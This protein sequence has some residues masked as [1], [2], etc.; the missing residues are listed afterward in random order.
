[1]AETIAHPGLLLGM[2]RFYHSPRLSMRGVLD[3]APTESRLLVYMMFGLVIMLAGKLLQLAMEVP[4]GTERF[5]SRAVA[6]AGAWLFITPL[7]YYALAAIGTLISKLFRGHGGWQS[8]RAAF[9]WASLVSAPIMAL[10]YIV[11]PMIV[12]APAWVPA[13]VIQLGPV[14]FIWA[15]AQCFAE[16]FEFRQVWMVFATMSAPILA[17]FVV[18]RLAG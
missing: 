7:V 8:G 14:F 12:S 10:S 13:A 4:P 1:M 17:I 18:L 5:M 2:A 6:E 3:S 11:P 9:F 15:L 16:A